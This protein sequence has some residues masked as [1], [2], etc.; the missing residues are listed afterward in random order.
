MEQG[1]IDADTT[2][3]WGPL[4]LQEVTA[5]AALLMR[6]LATL[7]MMQSA[8]LILRHLALHQLHLGQHWSSHR[9]LG[10]ALIVLRQICQSRAHQCSIT[11][12]GEAHA[13]FSCLSCACL[14]A[15]RKCVGLPVQ[16]MC[17]QH[18][19]LYGCSSSV[20]LCSSDAKPMASVFLV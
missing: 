19:E 4:S 8:A 12:E 11:Y 6:H 7:V 9:L 15:M 16:M 3:R 20:S 14:F 13:T 10:M 5:K 17:H 2:C 1:L 18:W